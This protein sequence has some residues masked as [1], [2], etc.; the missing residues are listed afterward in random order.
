MLQVVAFTGDAGALLAHLWIALWF[1]T[2]IEISLLK[3]FTYYKNHE[4]PSSTPPFVLSLVAGR[5]VAGKWLV[6]L[7][8]FC[9]RWVATEPGDRI[10]HVRRRG[11]GNRSLSLRESVPD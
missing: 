3:A 6:L 5:P 2:G 9:N 1:R 8:G 4:W 7:R 11:F 10:W